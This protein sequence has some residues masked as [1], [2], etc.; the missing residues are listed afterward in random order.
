ML[1][2]QNATAN[3]ITAF[4][5]KL[6]AHS[7]EST[8]KWSTDI[9]IFKA[10]S[11]YVKA[12]AEKQAS[13]AGNKF[14]YTISLGDEPSLLH[15]LINQS[16]ITTSSVVPAAVLSSGISIGCADPLDAMIMSKLQSVWNIRQTLKSDEGFSYV[17]ENGRLVIRTANLF[18]H[19]NFKNFVIVVEIH[20][21]FGDFNGK[22]EEIIR[23]YDFPMGKI[24]TEKL[25]AGSSRS[26]DLC[27]QLVEAL[28]F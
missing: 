12:S 2:V 7:P 1:N 16:V 23:K 17:L 24:A 5:D 22:V 21:D 13:G 10:N 19:G 3:N 9:K 26:A 4:H 15:T 25:S 14:L 11:S 8:G 27:G 28:S 18:L 20:E 6:S